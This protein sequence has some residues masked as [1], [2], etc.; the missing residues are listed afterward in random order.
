MKVERNIELG[1]LLQTYGML[2]TER[3][4]RL[5]AMKVDEDLSLAEI[6]ANEGI[7]RQGVRDALMRA[8]TQLHAYESALK[9]SE[10][11]IETDKALRSIKNDMNALHLHEADQA[12]LLDKVARL[13]NIWGTEDGV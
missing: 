7:S 1:L 12:A 5:L 10:R 6:A 4:R 11:L 8:E 13:Q 2:L 3:R 9:L